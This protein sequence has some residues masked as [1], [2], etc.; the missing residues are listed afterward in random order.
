MKILIIHT[1]GTIS[2]IL[3]NGILTPSADIA[4]SIDRMFRDVRG[5][6][7][8]HKHLPPVL[9]ENTDG[10]VLNKIVSSVQKPVLSGKYEGVIVTVGSDALAYTSAAISYA[11]GLS[12]TPCITVCSDLPLSCAEASGKA[13]LKAAFSVIRSK[14]AFGALTVYENRDGS[15]SVYRASRI[16]QQ[17][18]Y[19]SAPVPVGESYGTVKNG[20][21]ILNEKYKEA[22][23]SF[24]VEK[25]RF[26]TVSPIAF[27]HAYPGMIYPALPLRTKAVILG[28]YH[29]GTVNTISEETVKFAKRCRKRGINVYISGISDGSDYESMKKYDELGF[30]R[31]PLC[32]SPEALLIKLWLLNSGLK[33]FTDERL[34]YPLGGDLKEMPTVKTDN[35]TA[36]KSSTEEG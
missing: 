35:G 29:S 10:K 25:C 22:P 28:A 11:V 19:F 5:V 21:L 1:G 24:T 17:P 32:S 26:S 30:I 23:D 15:V 13:N 12:K 34:F 6:K 3:K 31:L 9:S 18:L 8:V 33:K 27:W 16:M 14:K 4:P 2:C 20:E 7:L 36:T